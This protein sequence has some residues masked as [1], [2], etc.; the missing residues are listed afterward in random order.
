MSESY[1][2]SPVITYV[3]WFPV[4][5]VIELYRLLAVGISL[6]NQFAVPVLFSVFW[7]V[8]FV[9]QLCSDIMSGNAASAAHQG[10]MFFLLTRCDVIISPRAPLYHLDP[11]CVGVCFSKSTD[12]FAVCLSVVPHRT[13]FWV[14]P[15]W[16]PIWLSGCS[17]YASFTWEVMQLFRMRTSCTGEMFSVYSLQSTEHI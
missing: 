15:S 12:V 11:H 8:L 4:L 6:W 2:W 7:F 5:Q 10:I 9:V 13:L 1:I 17:T 14:S 3:S 16:C